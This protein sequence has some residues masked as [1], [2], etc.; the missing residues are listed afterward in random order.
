ML[1]FMIFCAALGFLFG[2]PVGAALG[3]VLSV[4]IAAIL[5]RIDPW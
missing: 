3:V 2:G 1:E 5:E 4:V